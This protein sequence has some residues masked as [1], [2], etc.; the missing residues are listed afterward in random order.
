[1]IITLQKYF[2][3]ETSGTFSCGTSG[4]DVKC[5][6]VAGVGKTCICE[7]DLCNGGQTNFGSTWIMIPIG[8]LTV[9]LYRQW[10][11]VSSFANLTSWQ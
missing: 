11:S 8:I 9:Y 7:T 5:T 2:V 4:E 3:A 6:E 1:M 10:Y